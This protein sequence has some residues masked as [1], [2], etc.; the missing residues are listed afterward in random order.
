[1]C[2]LT[3]TQH[4]GYRSVDVLQHEEW[5]KIFYCPQLIDDLQ[6]SSTLRNGV[7]C[8]AESSSAMGHRITIITTVGGDGLFRRSCHDLRAML[9]LARKK[10]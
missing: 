2:G 1:M 10:A 5:R 6:I 9:R 7:A 4:L 8:D 3:E